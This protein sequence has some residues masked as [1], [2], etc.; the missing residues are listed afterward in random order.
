MAYKVTIPAAQFI[1]KQ[2][3][4]LIEA[5]METLYEQIYNLCPD[6]ERD[7]TFCEVI[8]KQFERFKQNISLYETKQQ[9]GIRDYLRLLLHTISNFLHKKGYT[10]VEKL[11]DEYS[12]EYF[13][14]NKTSV[15]RNKAEKKEAENKEE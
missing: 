8:C 15:Q 9:S 13:S 1:D 5:T 11:V 6:N 3:K 12:D 7:S 2:G 14:G 4:M 10:E